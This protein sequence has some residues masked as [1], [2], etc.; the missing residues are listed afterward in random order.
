[1]ASVQVVCL[2]SIFTLFTFT[3]S[4]S[5]SSP[6]SS[7]PLNLSTITIPLSHLFKHPSSD[8][9][10]TH[11]FIASASLNRAHHIRHPKSNSS[12][13]SKAPIYA[14]SYGGY[15]INL[16]FG[17]PP[18]TIPFILDTGSSLNWFPCTSRYLCSKCSFPN[19][20]PTKIPTFIPKN[21]SSS[22]IVGCANPKC[23]YIF[24]SS[25]Q[26]R[27]Q[28]CSPS[29]K[30]CSQPCP[31][32]INQYG[33]GSTAGVLLS[34]NLDFPGKIVPDFL[35]GCSIFSTRQPAGIAGFGRGPQS[36]PSQIGLKKFSY[37][38]LPHQFD[39]KPESSELVLDS[40]SYGHAKTRGLSYTPFHKNPEVQN[41]A[42]LEYYYLTLRK[43][44]VGDKHVK[45]PYQ[46]LV[47]GSDGNGGTIVDSGSTFTF[48][49]RPI[50][51]LVAQEFEKQ[52]ANYTRAKAVE[53]QSGLRPCFDISAEKSVNFPEFTFQF[54]GG[55]K[56]VLPLLNYFSLI[57]KS[58]VVCLTIVS[59]N[60]GGP[61]V[62]G[63]PAIILGNY[64][65]Q[66]F[67]IEYDLENERFG[68]QHQSSKRSP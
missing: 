50:F 66:N 2:V 31:I 60:V 59:D 19:I 64:Q 43:I 25:V 58:G 24:G 47:P 62:A 6:S 22:K 65:Q 13:L 16:S 35:V 44:I 61:G 52:M 54:K 34:E 42:F 38:L 11:K 8:P 30:N 45:I 51:E 17:T 40:G 27:C 9:L 26:S 7:T 68:F 56:M 63:G 1:M 33:L 49:E 57:G 3:S 14:K 48:I 41:S 15:S 67:Y 18:Q 12:S 37:C 29:S 39:D 53:A 28:D 5:S 21:S 4:P 23:G 32:Y 55:A 36:L 20:D 46:F 10:Q